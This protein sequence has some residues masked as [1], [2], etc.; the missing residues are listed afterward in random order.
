[1]AR[2]GKSIPMH[3][4][5]RISVSVRPISNGYIA[6]HSHDG[7]KGYVHKET[8]HPTKPKLTVGMDTVDSAM[9]K[10]AP[11]SPKRP[12][13]KTVTKTSMPKAAPGNGDKPLGKYK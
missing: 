1:M 5:E 4:D 8:F 9:K 12:V 3:T 6:S 7:P 2:G 10:G 13:A 11:A